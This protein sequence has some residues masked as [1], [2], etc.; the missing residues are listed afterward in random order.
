MPFNSLREKIAEE[1]AS[2]DRQ[3][4]WEKWDTGEFDMK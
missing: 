1:Q 4:C 3:N 2:L